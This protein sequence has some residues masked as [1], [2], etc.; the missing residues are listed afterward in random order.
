[1]NQF[2]PY[3]SGYGISLDT[4]CISGKETLNVFKYMFRYK[5]YDYVWIQRKALPVVLLKFISLWTK[6]IYDFDDAIYVRE[7]MTKDTISPQNRGV[8]GRFNY[9]LK[10]SALVFAGNATLK[11]YA[12]KFNPVVHIIPTSLELPEIH[13]RQAVET[14]VVT[15]GWIGVNSNLFFLKFI[16]QATHYIQNKYPNVRFSVMSGKKPEDLITEWEFTDWS[17]DNEKIWL[18]SIDIGIM[19]LTD[20]EWSRGKCAFKLLQYMAYGKPVVATDVGANRDVVSPGVNGFLVADV[21]E[22]TRA[23]EELVTQNDLRN[24]MGCNGKALYEKN[25]KRE[26]VQQR[27]SDL[28]RNDYIQRNR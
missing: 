12:E 11:S 27:I 17:T 2:L 1:M 18:S 23:L 15:I 24:T 25:Y 16:D 4:V 3:W 7:C 9:T 6:V 13:I 8:I 28:I 21:T 14:E 22:W 19:P 10:K 5:E 26:L 20:D